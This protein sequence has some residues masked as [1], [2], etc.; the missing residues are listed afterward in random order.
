MYRALSTI[1]SRMSTIQKET[2]V[3]CCYPEFHVPLQS[4]VATAI[5]CLLLYC[6]CVCM[7]DIYMIFSLTIF[8]VQIM[9]MFGHINLCVLALSDSTLSWV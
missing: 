4:S 9:Y 6:T 2:L 1:T 5:I 7:Y 3:S 8:G